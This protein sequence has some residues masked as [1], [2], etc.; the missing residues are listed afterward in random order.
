ME[1]EMVTEITDEEME[2][3]RAAGSLQNRCKSTGPAGVFAVWPIVRQKK[4]L[5]VKTP[6]AALFFIC[7][8]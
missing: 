5:P 8:R 7:E 1:F 3:A 6:W 4:R 2:L